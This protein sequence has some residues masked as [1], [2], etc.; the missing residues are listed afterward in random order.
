MFNE[1]DPTAIKYSDMLLAKARMLVEAGALLTTVA[2]VTYPRK[3]GDLTYIQEVYDD[4]VNAITK[5]SKFTVYNNERM[6]VWSGNR[7]YISEPGKIYYYK[8][9][10]MFTL[11]SKSSRLFSSEKF[12]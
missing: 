8:E 3:Q 1:D 4:H 9:D 10:M 6:V 2:N 7:L 5:G 11:T 12:Y